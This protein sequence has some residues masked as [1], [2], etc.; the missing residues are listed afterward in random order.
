MDQRNCQIHFHF[1]SFSLRTQSLLIFSQHQFL[2][3]IIYRD[4]PLGNI[5]LHWVFGTG[6]TEL[7]CRFIDSTKSRT[8]KEPIRTKWL[9][10]HSSAVNPRRVKRTKKHNTEVVRTQ[11]WRWSTPGS[12]RFLDGFV[13]P[14]DVGTHSIR[15]DCLQTS[16]G[17][18]KASAITSMGRCNVRPECPIDFLIWWVPGW[19]YFADLMNIFLYISRF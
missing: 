11:R 6:I 4:T 19:Q 7:Q 3:R 13:S 2:A 17:G 16:W 10:L 9:T 14:E 1:S 12:T 15:W 8:L 5:P 18:L